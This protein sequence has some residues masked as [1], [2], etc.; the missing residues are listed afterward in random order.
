MIRHFVGLI[1]LGLLTIGPIGEAAAERVLRIDEV[2]VGEL[3]P[4]KAIDYADS[5]L[6]MN[7][8]DTLVFPKPGGGV[9][10]ALAEKWTVAPDG[11]TVT[12]SLRAGA[13][14]HDGADVTAE[15]VVFSLERMVALGK[16]YAHLFKGISATA[17]DKATVVFK[18]P[19]A[20]AP[21]FASLVRLPVLNK[22]LVLKNKQAGEHPQFG[23]WGQAFLSTNDAG[24]GAYRVTSHNP[25]DLTVMARFDKYF[26]SFASN[27]PDTA[28]IRYGLEPATVRTLMPRREH[29][30]TS[31]WLPQ[32]IKKALAEIGGID[33]VAEAGIAYFILPMNTQRPPT[34]DV[35]VR[36]AIAHG[37]DYDALI[38]LL[39][40]TDKV[41]AAAPMRGALPS[42]LLGASKTLP[43]NKR[44]LAKAKAEMAKSKYATGG[45][46]PLDLIWVAEV[47]LEE[48]IGFLIQQNLREIGLDVKL[49]KVPWVLLQERVTKVETTPNMT[50]R[51]VQAPYPDPDALIGQ[52]H[53]GFRGRTLNMSWLQD[54]ELDGLLDQARA[55]LD[56]ARRVEIYRKAQ[57]RL[58]DQQPAIWAFESLS[59]FA[60]QAYVMAPPLEK[61]DQGVAVQ[62][63]N[64]RFRLWSVN[65]R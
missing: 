46:P 26:G 20:S 38:G 7:V 49:T 37:L 61:S 65:P 34:D 9:V 13:R 43:E 3:D 5:I 47:A 15:D 32:E 8:Y 11:K 6:M 22:A 48:K 59:V 55:A 57:E 35:H 62:G 31:Q 17:P 29:E 44:D 40:I 30:V 58:L 60:K 23:D 56:D 42:G 28:R 27:A 36:R 10:P 41:T 25:Q 14:F 19:A 64:W 12:F 52:N 18:L 63:G 2:P 4:A 24:S 16:G 45:A 54:A 1:V 39:R 33:L 50:Q 53:S 21:F 51:F